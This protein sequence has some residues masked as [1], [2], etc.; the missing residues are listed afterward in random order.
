MVQIEECPEELTEFSYT[1]PARIIS[2]S[3]CKYRAVDNICW[4][5][6]YRKKEHGRVVH[7]KR[8]DALQ[9]E[10]DCCKNICPFLKEE[11]RK[12]NNVMM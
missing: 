8:Y 1:I 3:R 9:E 4:H 12:S 11:F 10:H 6:K 2:N 7:Y 5:P